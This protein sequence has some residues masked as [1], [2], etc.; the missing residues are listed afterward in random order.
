MFQIYTKDNCIYCTKAKEILNI[1]SLPYTEKIVKTQED[2][3]EIQRRVGEAKKINVVP[4][5]FIG[6]EYIGGYIEFVEF[7]AKNSNI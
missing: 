6:D 5:F 3:D 1:R 4:Q 2:K 7:L